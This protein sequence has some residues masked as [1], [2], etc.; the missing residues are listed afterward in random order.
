MSKTVVV[1][2]RSRTGTSMLSGILSKLGVF[3]GEVDNP[4]VFNPKGSF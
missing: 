2:G 4:T 1:I 3:M